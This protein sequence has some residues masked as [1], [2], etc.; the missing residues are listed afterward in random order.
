M[1]MHVD[2]LLPW[3]VYL[4]EY[5]DLQDIYHHYEYYEEV[6]VQ[7]ENEEEENFSSIYLTATPYN[8]YCICTCIGQDNLA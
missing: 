5:W 7:E 3:H 1:E 4:F 8:L 6:G 2:N